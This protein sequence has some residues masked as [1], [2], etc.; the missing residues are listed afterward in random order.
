MSIFLFN[1]NYTQIFNI[2]LDIYVLDILLLVV[3]LNTSM[4]KQMNNI[5]QIICLMNMFIK[6]F[7]YVNNNF[8]FQEG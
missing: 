1:K 2:F 8:K 5:N 4:M 3:C 7:K 6:F